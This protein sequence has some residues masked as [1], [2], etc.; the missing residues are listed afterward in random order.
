MNNERKIPD[1]ETRARNIENWRDAI[2]QI[3]ALTFKLD[4]LI[5]MAEVEKRNCPLTKHRLGKYY[6]PSIS[7]VS[8]EIS[9]SEC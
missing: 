1:A 5:A 4:E 2:R 7:I 9:T 6:N 3:D 8:K